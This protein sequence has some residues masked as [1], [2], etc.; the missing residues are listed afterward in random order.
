MT[1]NKNNIYQKNLASRIDGLESSIIRDI[2]SKLKDTNLISF[3]SGAPDTQTLPGELL[4]ELNELA[5][6]DYGNSILQYGATEGFQPL[7]EII[8]KKFSSRLNTV[9]EN[10]IFI[11]SG[12]QSVLH[13]ATMAF[14]N[15]LDKIG[16]E[17]PTFLGALK[18]F[19][20]YEP[21]II[22]I[23]TDDEGMTIDSLTEVIKKHPLKFL[24]IIPTF[25]NPTGTSMSLKRKKELAR[26]A[27]KNDLIIIEDDPYYDLRYLGKD[28]PTLY[29]L[30]PNNVIYVGS[31]SKSFSPGMRLG[32]FVASEKI[33]KVLVTLKQGI[34]LHAST[35]AQA[36]ATVFLQ[37]G[38]FDTHNKKV[39]KIYSSRLEKMHEELSNLLGSEF[40]W[41]KPEGGMF[42]WLR[43]NKNIDTLALYQKA[44]KNGLA[45]IPGKPFFV[46]KESNN[47]IRLNFTGMTEKKIAKGIKKLSDIYYEK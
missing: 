9:S 42:L 33:S 34:D 40:T 38:Y 2:F 5:L 44:I 31:L 35:Y 23:N 15:P 41:K 11:S 4:A 25:Q 10:N 28:M 46:G 21:N 32:F 36:L 18:T 22:P 1:D 7:R 8:A 14:I 27:I 37:Q 13:L 17:N 24:Y 43:C 6:K 26:L 29:S 30:A 47:Y 3:A 39:N 16:V 12:A 45:F 19:Q 20:A